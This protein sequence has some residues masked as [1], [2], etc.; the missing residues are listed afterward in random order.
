MVTENI[1][2]LAMRNLKLELVILY[3]VSRISVTV[4]LNANKRIRAY[5]SHYIKFFF[6]FVFL[7]TPTTVNILTKRKKKTNFICG[8]YTSTTLYVF[9]DETQK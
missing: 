3:Q 6:T 2:K 4:C 5:F 7:S 9:P 8:P 1:C